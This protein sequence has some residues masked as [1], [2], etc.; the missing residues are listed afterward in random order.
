MAGVTGLT[1]DEVVAALLDVARALDRRPKR[2]SRADAAPPP[3]TGG[4]G[5]HP[6]HR[7]TRAVGWAD[8]LGPHGWEPVRQ[9]GGVTYWRRPGKRVG[10][11]AT[12][13]Y[14]KG[15]KNG[16]LLYVFSTNADPFE[17][18]V[19]YSKFA[20]YCLLDHAG[21]W[22]AAARHL[23]DNGYGGADEPR[24]VFGDPPRPGAEP[25]QGR[26]G[27]GSDAEFWT[28]DQLMTARFSAVRYIVHEL[29]ADESLTIL[30]GVQKGGKTWLALQIA[31]CVA[32]GV[33]LFDRAVDPGEVIYLA[34][35]D[36]ARRLQDR[37][38]K[39]KAGAAL[40]ILWYTKFPKLDSKDGWPLLADLAA[41]RPK[42]L[43]VDTLAAAKSGKTDE[44]GSG[45][46][47]DFFNG[48]RELAQ[49]HQIG[50]L[51]VHHHGKTITGDPA[52]DLRGSSA[53]GAAADVLLGL[54]RVRRRKSGKEAVKGDEH[55]PEDED[56]PDF[57][58]KARGRDIEDTTLAI[59]FGAHA[60][61]LWSLNPA[62]THDGRVTKKGLTIDAVHAALTQI[63]AGTVAEIAAKAGVG[64]QTARNRLK[65]LVESGV[66]D[67][68]LATSDGGRKACVYFLKG[69]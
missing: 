31:Q 7:Y 47:A 6:G 20:A 57:Y 41:R 44:D 40:P 46:M 36:G 65:E 10:L 60:D 28:H 55:D 48:L 25:T 61:W 5:D 26:P 59:S 35:E 68:H 9:V 33:P 45:P 29:I 67:S 37:L 8:V 23:A 53:I 69:R 21:D 52:H 22:R 62:G 58:L 12:T 56:S 2:V 18:G 54:Y 24:V 49:R 63:G 66:V 50:I 11:S 19:T 51:V 4:D 27:S 30:G 39:Q 64:E 13:G 3:A 43:I 42:L 38:V 1:T 34:L 16:D 32:N 14:A 15:E 17:A